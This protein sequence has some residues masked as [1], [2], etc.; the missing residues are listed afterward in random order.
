MKKFGFTLAELL[1]SLAIV[2]VASALMVPAFNNIMPDKYKTRVLKYY[3]MVANATN[4]ML[5]NEALYYEVNNARGVPCIGLECDGV[6]LVPPYN[7][8]Q[9]SGLTKYRNILVDMLDLQQ[10][11]DST[12]ESPDGTKWFFRNVPIVN[13]GMVTTIRL[14]FDSKDNNND[15]CSFTRNTCENPNVFR[16]K[17]NREGNVS[18]GDAMTDAYLHNPTNR[19]KK[20]DRETAKG[21]LAAGKRY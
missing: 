8:A 13:Q 10:V 7:N 15:N 4:D 2:A 19:D 17:V 9:F 6:P 16:L 1:I 12:Y 21:Y 20:A 14:T 3:S 11:G 5:E 18:A